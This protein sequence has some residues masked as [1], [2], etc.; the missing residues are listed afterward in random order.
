MKSRHNGRQTA[1]RG[2]AIDPVGTIGK[3]GT[4]R[5]GVVRDESYAA[6]VDNRRKS[7]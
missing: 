1:A 3:D 4:P 6:T 2:M 5:V 7:V